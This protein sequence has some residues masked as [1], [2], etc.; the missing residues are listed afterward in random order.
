MDV[1]TTCAFPAAELP[2]LPQ[3]PC[4]HWDDREPSDPPL[5]GETSPAPQKLHAEW[6]GSAVLVVV[7]RGPASGVSQ[8]SV[9]VV[10][11]GSAA[12]GL[13]ASEETQARALGAKSSRPFECRSYT[14]QA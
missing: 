12:V 1:R 14:H 6:L 4:A 9:A 3:K 7:T 11:Q 10:S 13:S 2:Y 5:V 8:E